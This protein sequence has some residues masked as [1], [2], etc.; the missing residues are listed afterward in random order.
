MAQFQPKLSDVIACVD[1]YHKIKDAQWLIES[2]KDAIVSH[3]EHPKLKD[4]L[5]CLLDHYDDEMTKLIPEMD[6]AFEKV[7]ADRDLDKE[8]KDFIN[9]TNE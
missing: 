1:I 3:W 5:A 6:Q 2:M 8:W 7:Q 9:G 4:H